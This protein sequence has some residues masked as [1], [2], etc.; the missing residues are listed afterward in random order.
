M[1]PQFNSKISVCCKRESFVEINVGKYVSILT[2]VC[3]LLCLGISATAQCVGQS[4]DISITRNIGCSFGQGSNAQW[5][6]PAG[7][8]INDPGGSSSTFTVTWTASGT[9][10]LKRT[11]PSGCGATV[12]YSSYYAV[13]AKPATPSSTEVNSN[14][15]TC[16]QVTLNYTGT[17]PETYWQTS[18]TGTDVSSRLTRTVTSPGTYYARIKGST[19]CWGDARALSVTSIPASPSGGSLSGGGT[20]IG[21]V[22]TTLSLSGQSGSVKEYWYTENNG[23]P[24]RVASVSTSINVNLSNST[25]SAI[26][27]TYWAV[28][29]LNGCDAN[30]SSVNVT[31]NPPPT[32]SRFVCVGDVTGHSI[33]RSIG[34]SYGWGSN[35]TF[36]GASGG[37]INDPGGSE[38]GFTV[39]W[40]TAGVF[41]L[42]RTFPNGCGTNVIYGETVQVYPLP[43]APTTAEVTKTT[44]CGSATLT[45]TGAEAAYWQT[46]ANAFDTNFPTAKT[47]T[48]SG[49]YYLRKRSPEGCWSSAL[50]YNVPSIPVVPAGGTLNGGNTFA[51]YANIDLTLSAYNGTIKEYYY[52]ENGGVTVK[53]A[54][55]TATV[56]VLFTNAGSTNLTREY[57]AVVQLNGCEANSSLA[58]VIVTPRA[59]IETPDVSYSCS[60]NGI[61]V[62]L[63]TN[64]TADRW[65]NAATG[66]TALSASNSISVSLAAATFYVERKATDGRT[67]RTPYQVDATFAERCKDHLNYIKMYHPQEPLSVLTLTEGPAQLQRA[68]EYFDGSGRSVEKI[69]IANS[70]LGFDL[71]LPIV[72]DANGREYRKYL[73]YVASTADG[74][75]KP[76]SFKTD[77]NYNHNFYNNTAD[78]VADDSRPFSE[79]VYELSPLNRPLRMYGAGYAW[80]SA[81]NNKFTEYKNLL[82]VYSTAA[83]DPT[84]HERIIAWEIS[85][86]GMPVRKGAL[87]NVIATGG[88]YMSSQLI[89]EVTKDESGSEVRQYRNKEGQLILKKMQSVTSPQLDNRDHWAQTYYVY[90]EFG[91][92]RFVLQ[93]ELVRSVLQ[94]DS[95]NPSATDLD[96][97][98]YQY[99]YD[100]RKRMTMKRVP[101]ADWMYMVYDNRDRL[102]LTQDGSQRQQNKWIFNKYDAFNR[103]ILTGVYTHG[104]AVDQSTMSGLVT[105]TAFEQYDGTSGNHG[106]TNAMFPTSGT[107]VLTVNYYDNYSFKSL[108]SGDVSPVSPTDF[109][110][111]P[112]LAGMEPLSGVLTS[113]MKIST[114]VKTK[115]V[116][117][118]SYLWTVNYYDK[119]YQ[120]AQSVSSNHKSG[121]DRTSF[122]YDFRGKVK[123]K[124]TV[125]GTNGGLTWRNDINAVIDGFCIRKKTTVAAWDASV[126]SNQELPA[127]KNGFIEHTVSNVTDVKMVGFTDAATTPSYTDIDYALYLTG[128]SLRIYQSGTSI[129]TFGTIAVNDILRIERNGTTVTYKKNGVT[130]YTSSVA[131]SNRLFID[132]ALYSANS[133]VCLTS[134]GFEYPTRSIVY[135][136]FFYDYASRLKK[137]EHSVNNKAPIVLFQNSY[138]ELGQLTDKKLH[139]AGSSFAQSLDYRYNIRGWL[140]AINSSDLTKTDVDDAYDYFGMNLSYN[141]DLGTGNIRYYNGNISG[142]KW[143]RNTLSEPVIQRAY[144]YGYDAMSRL[145]AATYREHN[146]T[147][148]SNATNAF[149]ESNFQYDLNG[150]ILSLTRRG[151]GG[152]LMDNLTFDYGTTKSNKLIS[153][154]DSEPAAIGFID[155]N[156]TGADYSY[157]P[158]GN[159][160][161]DMNKGINTDIIYNTLNLPEKITLASGDYIKYTYAADGSKLSQQVYTASGQT[162]SKQ[163]DYIGDFVYENHSLQYIQ[164]VEGRVIPLAES[165]VNLIANADADAL[166]GFTSTGATVSLSLEG[167]NGETYVK[168]SSSITSGAGGVFPIGGTFT[169]QA[170]EQYVF[171]VLGYRS[172]KDVYLYVWGNNGN[173]IWTGSTLPSGA[174]N[175]AWISQSFTIPSGCTQLRVGLRWNAASSGE[176]MFINKVGLYKAVPEYQYHVKDHLGNVRLT[177]STKT[178]EVGYLA[179]MEDARS[180]KEQ[181]DFDPS[182]SRVTKISEV[183]PPL[184]NHTPGGNKATRLSAANSNEIIGL[185][186]SLRVAPGDVVKMEVYGKYYVPTSNPSNVSGLISSS[187][188]SAFGVSSATSGEAGMAKNALTSLFNAGPILGPSQWED[189][190][191]PKAFINY[192]LF[193][194]NFQMYDIG[195]D[196]ISAGAEISPTNT[197]APFDYMKLTAN[198]TKPGF[199]YVYLSNE[200]DKITDVYFDDFKITHQSKAGVIQA[201][202]YYAFGMSTNPYRK[203]ESLPNPNLFN[204]KEVQDE[205][206]IGW[207]DFGP[208]MYMPEI[209][210]FGGIDILTQ[211]MPGISPYS[212]SFNNPIRFSDPSGMAPLDGVGADGLTNEQW[213]EASRPGANPALYDMF[214]DQNRAAEL[215]QNRA[216]A[217]AEYYTYE[218]G[219]KWYDENGVEHKNIEGTI[220]FMIV[221]TD[222]VKELVLEDDEKTEGGPT[223]W[224]IMKELMKLQLR[225]ALHLPDAI[226]FGGNIE[227]VPGMGGGVIERGKL[228]VLNGM[229]AG[230]KRK[231]L[232]FGIA[233]LGIDGGVSVVVTEYYY[234]NLSGKPY[235]FSIKDHE[236]PR[237]NISADVN[238]YGVISVGAGF[239]IA[240]VNGMESGLFII[241]RSSSLGIGIE[242]SPVS[243]N[244]NFGSTEFLKD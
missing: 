56:P 221:T 8:T 96:N 139:S 188:T 79:T 98:G 57:W 133:S 118:S 42:K 91:M 44:S 183:V 40:T 211:M 240:P 162:L 185:A 46:S 54:N 112:D 205:L 187:I 176:T 147:T 67:F 74:S 101:G 53:V 82:N 128:T 114:G 75:F 99:K 132:V 242:G 7:G 236:G 201:D 218:W 181:G 119:F 226:S 68:I 109:D 1:T 125:H 206:G 182:Y 124:K 200:S 81:S 10:R 76:H 138:N 121:F 61:S 60:S 233:V 230:E 113:A 9:F 158:S 51:G 222:N 157:D 6:G 13:G 45:Y 173:I 170:G 189:A 153:V 106:Y 65:F 30:S 228:Y 33:T 217:N 62:I 41:T 71:V 192:I 80:S 155:L 88:Y 50:T 23:T 89:I 179:T 48:T 26:T 244:L 232:D 21:T 52:R 229:S 111:T 12:I 152:V 129:G 104:T 191:A 223:K 120:L 208:R 172:A 37:S 94:S 168:A 145:S 107:E 15:G 43:S 70:P 212:Y 102:R 3:G 90:D 123:E 78:D 39:T 239:S 86:S 103:I 110:Y 47:V 237:M 29:T 144:N 84:R 36:E 115:I 87:T 216:Q 117:T 72:Y 69:A 137:V 17:N 127:S 126:T 199:I 241:S 204:G 174:A 5:D 207:L 235:D 195:F 25:G 178:D 184:Y 166:T 197:T 28:V 143:S 219:T 22:N 93:P 16:G 140:N 234:V 14:S 131:S 97:Y 24:I 18:A 95:Y 141:D 134:S 231:Y 238:I 224:D 116:G 214:R 92:L 135:Q 198:V 34:C 108:L 63:T 160:K 85:A 154:T 27:R 4:S 203:A 193:D 210:R 194:Q 31:V 156:K 209:G 35:A 213:I 2:L 243:G 227:S 64:N 19:A 146:G 150:N 190:S 77:G 100:A 130:I 105:A 73:P 142:I 163:T 66:G 122:I 11:F 169:V 186:K 136:K 196:Q 175:E 180:S 148:W 20:Y 149:N 55:T 32:P 159:L 59:S 38:S 164:H 220:D 177:F 225:M 165:G 83:A 49:N 202:D 161:I 215:A 167:V 151:V 171:R 58:T